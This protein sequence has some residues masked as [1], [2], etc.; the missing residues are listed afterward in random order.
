[1]P[2]CR[3]ALFYIA[4]GP[5]LEARKCPASRVGTG[6]SGVRVGASAV[7]VASASGRRATSVATRSEA[8]AGGTAQPDREC[9]HEEEDVESSQIARWAVGDGATWR[10]QRNRIG[11]DL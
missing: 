8:A 7:S 1:M 4:N 11:L 9:L 10:P 6:G 3:G 5:W 2:A